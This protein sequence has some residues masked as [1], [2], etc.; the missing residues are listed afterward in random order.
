MYFKLKKVP[1][2]VQFS[3]IMKNIISQD[4]TD[5]NSALPPYGI[6]RQT[7]DKD[8]VPKSTDTQTG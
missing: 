2:L 7:S 4:W 6:S 3:E 1:E 8:F 5:R